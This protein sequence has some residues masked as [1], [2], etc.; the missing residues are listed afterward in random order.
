VDY[1]GQMLRSFGLPMTTGT[2]MV[3][4]D[5]TLTVTFRLEPR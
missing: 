2:D 1:I 5:V 4:T 3:P